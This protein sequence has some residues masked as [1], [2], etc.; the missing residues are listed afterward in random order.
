M[1]TAE[2]H[3]Y[4]TGSIAEEWHC[5]TSTSLGER[6]KANPAFFAVLWQD[7]GFTSVLKD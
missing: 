2:A 5:K 4:N 3:V 7:I 1:C 6:N